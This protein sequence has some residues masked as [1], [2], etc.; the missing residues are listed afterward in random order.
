DR[1]PRASPRCHACAPPPLHACAELLAAPIH[2]GHGGSVEDWGLLPQPYARCPSI[3]WRFT[4]DDHPPDLCRIC[5]GGKPTNH[6]VQEVGAAWICSPWMLGAGPGGGQPDH[7]ARGGQ[8]T[9]RP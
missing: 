4:G 3:L 5:S 8:P 9:S 2:A 1:R 7:P 6:G